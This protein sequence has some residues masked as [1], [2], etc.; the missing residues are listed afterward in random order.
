MF[1]FKNVNFEQ[2]VINFAE[3]I[4]GTQNAICLHVRRGDFVS[5]SMHNVIG[6]QYY[7]K[8]LELLKT[9]INGDFRV[10]IFS[11][12]TEWCRTNLIN[13]SSNVTIVDHD[14]AGKS[15]LAHFYLMTCFS[16]FIIPNSTFAWWAA[17][18][19][20]ANTKIVIA[21]QTWATIESSAPKDIVPDSWMAI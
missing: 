10:F 13:I 11:D 12:D 6:V 9:K 1:T 19:A 16:I 3:L 4:K 15:F 8:A 7:K 14:C 17:W 20:S 18:L 5:S 2:K 21:P